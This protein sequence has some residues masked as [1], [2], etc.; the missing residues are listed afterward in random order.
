MNK[1][2]K[3]GTE[4]EKKF[5]INFNRGSFSEFKKKFDI[6]QS[7]YAVRVEEK[8]YSVLSNNKVLPKSDV[9]LVD[10]NL[11][12]EFLNKHNYLLNEKNT[13]ELNLKKLL[14]SG[15]SIKR[16]DSKKYQIHKFTVSSFLKFI[17]IPAL[18]AG[19]SIYIKGDKTKFNR[20]ILEIWRCEEAEFMKYHKFVLK[21]FDQLNETELSEIKKLSNEQIKLIITSNENKLNY[22]F[23]GKGYF[24]EPYC[25][26]W[27]YERGKITELRPYDFT[28]TTGSGRLKSPTI[29]IKPK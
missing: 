15:I 14:N 18:A 29:V 6:K 13:K 11:N 21:K 5:V 22:I 4:E 28:V 25:A 19:S 2:T 26:S 16:E 1:G 23:S 8:H 7:I 10:S 27:L 20:K 12:S 9:Y 3:E 17:N 24:E